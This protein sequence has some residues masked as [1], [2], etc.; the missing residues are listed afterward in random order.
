MPETNP[1]KEAEALIKQTDKDNSQAERQKKTYQHREELLDFCNQ[2]VQK[3]GDWRRSS[4]ETKWETYRRNADGIY[5]PTLSERKEGW[6]SKVVVPI[7]SS[8]RE[9]AMSSLV[10]TLLPP[11]PLE[12]KSRGTIPEEADQGDNIRDLILREM[13]RSR[14]KKEFNRVI[15][16]ATTY[17]SGFCRVRFSIETEMRMVRKFDLERLD[18][19][20]IARS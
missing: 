18:P 16:D 8:H 9:T 5:D 10:R 1:E 2:F 13:D 11:K 4:Y 7:T 3:S 12:M 15:D 14:F 6:Q 20:S 17:G 19:T